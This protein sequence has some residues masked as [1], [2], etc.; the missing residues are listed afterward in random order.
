MVQCFNVVAMLLLTRC[1]PV[2]MLLLL[3][4]F[5]IKKIEY[6]IKNHVAR[7]LQGR[8]KVV[9]RLLLL[10]TFVINNF[11][12]YRILLIIGRCNFVANPLQ[13]CCNVVAFDYDCNQ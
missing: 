5:V 4:T 8:C 2:A 13:C 10:M 12:L 9:A 7:S 1:K 11:I 3:M 6:N